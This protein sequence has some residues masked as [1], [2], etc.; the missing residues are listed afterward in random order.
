MPSSA[1]VGLPVM[2]RPRAIWQPLRPRRR[3]P[4][5]PAKAADPSWTSGHPAIEHPRPVAV[6][7]DGID[8]T[9][10]PGKGDAGLGARVRRD[11]VKAGEEPLDLRPRPQHELFR[12]VLICLD[13]RP[14]G[15]WWQLVP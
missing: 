15:P 10:L 3:G 4:A 5:D 12:G 6:G 8:R 11:Q 2:V 14:D 9:P 7:G 13:H 1:T